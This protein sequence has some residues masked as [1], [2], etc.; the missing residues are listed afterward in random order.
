MKNEENKIGLTTD[1]ARKLIEL[2]EECMKM[3]VSE[4]SDVDQDFKKYLGR[5]LSAL[6]IDAESE[7]KNYNLRKMVS[8]RKKAI[9][10]IN[11][12]LGY[13][14]TADD[15]LNR[16]FSIAGNIDYPIANAIKQD[17]N[18]LKKPH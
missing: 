14:P 4:E 9:K 1:Q 3:V 10:A 15:L 7:N 12:Y 16:L 18:Q 2:S 13:S 8:V 6:A 17:I 5:Y 11:N